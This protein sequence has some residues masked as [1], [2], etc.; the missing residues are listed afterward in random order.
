MLKERT[1][2]LQ[3]LRDSSELIIDYIL[4][5]RAS[6][7]PAVLHYKYDKVSDKI[8]S[9]LEPSKSDHD[10]FREI[11][12]NMVAGEALRIIHQFFSCDTFTLIHTITWNGR[13]KDIS[14]ATGQPIE[15]CILS[16]RVPR[17]RYLELNLER[18]D[19]IPCLN[20]LGVRLS[21]DYPN[22]EPV[23]EFS[24]ITW[25]D[26]SEVSPSNTL[27][28]LD[29]IDPINFEHLI[30]NLL[31]KMGYRVEVTPPIKDG[32]IDVI[33]YDDRPLSRGKIVVQAKRY[34][35]VV[36]V[37]EVR[38][39]RGLLIEANAM[40]GL[41]ITTGRFTAGAIDAAN[42]TLVD[43]VDGEE[44]RRLLIDH[45]FGVIPKK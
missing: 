43:L 35:G 32:G 1:F 39:L 2:Q 34:Q 27:I 44:L 41:L 36:G 19:V 24:K 10:R 42:G 6:L 25:V 21:P 11:Y 12:N 29:T 18:V 16:V 13:V 30:G 38:A 40:K 22:T 15:P 9:V 31:H 26:K 14:R 45:G 23:S 17:K 3:F 37:A 4:P 8:A 5:E 20:H 28:D 7:L 33:A